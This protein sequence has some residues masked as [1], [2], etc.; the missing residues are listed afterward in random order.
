MFSTARIEL[1]ELVRLTHEIATKQ[2]TL[3][4]NPSIVPAESYY[5]TMAREEA[6]RIEL[7]KKYE[8]I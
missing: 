8:L 5:E 6:R 4:A 1:Q 7:L 3:A 2:A